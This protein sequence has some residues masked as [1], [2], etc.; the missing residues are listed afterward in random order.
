[1][2]GVQP[3]RAMVRSESAAQRLRSFGANT[4]L[5]D[6]HNRESVEHALEGCDAVVHLA[7]GHGATSAT[8][9]LVQ[10]AASKNV[11]HFVHIS[12]MSVHGPDPGPEA[13]HETTAKLG[14]Y[15][16]DYSDSKAEQ[17]ETV[18]S[19]FD[20]G[21]FNGIILRPT[22]VYGLGSPFVDRVLAE[23]ERGRVTMIDG[24]AGRCNTVYI[25]DVCDAIDVALCNREALGHAFFI[26]DDI[27]VSWGDFI[28][29]FAAFVPT[30]PQFISIS[31]SEARRYWAAN[32]PVSERGLAVRLGYKLRRVFG[33][34]PT[35]APF[36]PL[37]RIHRE[38][39]RINFSNARARDLLGWS[40]KLSFD[41]GVACT[42][43]AWEV[44]TRN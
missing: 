8:R 14:R 38:M 36:P 21:F 27:S 4:V 24:G 23:T 30:E 15:G 9:L 7:H 20:Q 17:E 5:A 39:V 22:V 13:E 12:T 28:R 26:T 43:A 25:D 35:P 16:N 41:Q 34:A 18:Q 40:P 19:A 2:A 3:Y 29:A 32:P 10:V 44:R 1:M 11:K 37:G 33:W 31:A 6:L 42:R